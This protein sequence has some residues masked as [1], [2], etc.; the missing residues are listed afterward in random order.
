MIKNS[1]GGILTESLAKYVRDEH[2][3]RVIRVRVINFCQ[4]DMS[5]SRRKHSIRPAKVYHAHIHFDCR[6]M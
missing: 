6:R 4:S 3:I 1:V 5:A 2:Q